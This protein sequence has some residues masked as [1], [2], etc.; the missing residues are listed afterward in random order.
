MDIKV[1][2]IIF[3]ISLSSLAAI[4]RLVKTRRIWERYAMVWVYAG[5]ALAILPFIVDGLDWVLYK[6]GVEYPPGFLLLIGIFAIL[7]L[8]LQFTVEITT[9]VRR[10]RNTVQ[11][12]AILEERVRQL[13]AALGRP[14]EEPKP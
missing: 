11:E 14:G 10:S 2:V 5:L 9:L 12:L 8:L 6:L 3:L 1:R 7:L 4:I 13:E